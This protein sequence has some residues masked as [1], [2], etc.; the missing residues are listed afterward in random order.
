[1]KTGSIDML[2]AASHPSVEVGGRRL[3]ED[4]LEPTLRAARGNAV[5]IHRMANG[6]VDFSE[7]YKVKLPTPK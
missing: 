3:K 7:V 1:M 2:P 4:G 6:L 5:G